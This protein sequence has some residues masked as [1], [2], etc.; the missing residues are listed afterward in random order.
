M[1]VSRMSDNFSRAAHSYDARARFQQTETKRVVD[2][3]QM[4]FPDQARILDIGC[5]TGWFAELSRPLSKAWNIF[6]LDIAAGMCDAARARC[7][8][9]QADAASLPVADNACDAVVSSLCVQ[10]V[11]DLPGTF[12]E[13]MRVLKPGG[14]AVIATLCQQSLSELREAAASAE[15]PLGLL[16]MR[17]AA[18]YERA[19]AAA[20]FTTTLFRHDVGAD[21]Y[22][23]MQTLLNSMRQIGAGNPAGS[24]GLMGAT[25]WKAMCAAYEKYRTPQGLPA[26]WDRL[27]MVLHKPL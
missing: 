8:P 27:F 5:G 14:R 21:Y 24:G 12:R 3:A 9:I 26:T 2:A 22:P 7:T 15:L 11:D 20:G 17:P 18:D 1:T 10:W 25:R 13:I 19:I 16:A 6:G 23:D 4:L